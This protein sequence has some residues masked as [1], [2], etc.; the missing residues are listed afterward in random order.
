M[1]TGEFNAGGYHAMD[2]HPFQ[3]GVEILLVALCYRTRDKPRPNGPLCSYA[4]FTL[5]FCLLCK[6]SMVTHNCTAKSH[7]YQFRF[8]FHGPQGRTTKYLCMQL[9]SSFFKKIH[10][11][12]Q[13]SY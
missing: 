3:G 2:K 4:D 9:T 13:S 1:G 11:R 6:L 8:N 7:G 5:P 10:K 12:L